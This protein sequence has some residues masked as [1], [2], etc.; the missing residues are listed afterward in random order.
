RSPIGEAEVVFNLVHTGDPATH[1]GDNGL[2]V[3]P[4]LHPLL[5]SLIL[6]GAC[7][8]GSRGVRGVLASP[9]LRPRPALLLGLSTRRDPFEHL[10][11]LVVTGAATELHVLTDLVVQP[12]GPKLRLIRGLLL[13]HNLHVPPRHSRPEAIL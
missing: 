3:Q 5:Q 10:G 6:R 2:S 13:R 9:P 7:D 4:R 8:L 1:A 12:L 11:K